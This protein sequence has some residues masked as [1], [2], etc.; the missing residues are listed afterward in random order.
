MKE[1]LDQVGAMPPGNAREVEE[2]GEERKQ[3]E[4]RG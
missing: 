2:E 4:I 3:E 1:S